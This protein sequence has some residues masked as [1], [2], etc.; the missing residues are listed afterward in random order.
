MMISMISDID[1]V[2]KFLAMHG[3]TSS[4]DIVKTIKNHRNKATCIVH[5]Y[6]KGKVQY[7]LKLFGLL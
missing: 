5:I 1:L 4:L 2:S 6:A 7:G 3:V